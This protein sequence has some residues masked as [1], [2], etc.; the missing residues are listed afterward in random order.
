MAWSNQQGR[1]PWSE[2]HQ[3]LN[4]LFGENSNVVTSD[5]V[6]VVDIKE[7]PNRF[8]L[9]AD[10]PGVDRDNIDI[11]MEDSVLSI[12]GQRQL[13]E[14]GEGGEHKR[15]ERAH[16]TFYRRFALPEEADPQG[17]RRAAIRGCSRWSSRSAKRCS[18]GGLRSVRKRRCAR[19]RYLQAQC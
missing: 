10:L 11:T 17:I 7:E 1:N 19:G 18:R 2:F 14:P 13:E 3:E 15:V 5:W 6:P 8:V 16:G 4:R 12:R 9:H